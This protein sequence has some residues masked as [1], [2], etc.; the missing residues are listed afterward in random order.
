MAIENISFG[1]G[2]FNRTEKSKKQNKNVQVPE[3]MTT[4]KSNRKHVNLAPYL[5][6]ALMIP[7]GGATLTSCVEQTVSVDE[8]ATQQLLAELLK[9]QQ[10]S[11]KIQQQM[12]EY[13][14]NN[15]S[16]NTQLM[17]LL[18][19]MMEQNQQISNILSGIAGDVSQI[20][21]AVVQ[22]S[23]MME[24][25]NAND[26]ELLN[27][28]DQ[29]IAGQGSDSEKLQQLIDLNAEQNNWLANIFGLIETANQF[30]EKLGETLQ[31]FY[32]DYRTNSDEFKQNDKDHTTMMNL[33]YEALLS[34]NEISTETLNAIKNIQNS[35][36]A[37]SAKLD[38][39]IKLL[40]SI[41]SK[42]DKL[43]EGIDNIGDNITVN[44][45]SLKEILT[46]FLNQYKADKITDHELLNN[47]INAFN[48]SN[49]NDQELLN[50]LN[51]IQAQ[52]ASG[53]LA[54]SEGIDKI[55]DLLNQI[56]S[57][58]DQ[59]VSELQSIAEQLG[60][61]FMVDGKPLA[62]LVKE[63][64]EMYKAGTITTNG[65]LTEINNKIQQGL[66][67]DNANN[68]GILAKLDEISQKISNGQMS[69][70]EGMS[71]ISD[72]LNSIN[73]NIQNISGQLSTISS[74]IDKGIDQLNKNHNETLDMLSNINNGIGSIDSKLND[75]KANQEISNDKL[76][77]ISNK[78]DE[79]NAQLGQINQKTIS[80]DQLKEMLGPMFDE[81]SNDLTII[82]GNQVSIEDLDQLLDKYKTDLTTTN[83]LIENLTS[84]VRNLDLSVDMGEGFQGIIDAINDFKNQQ[85]GTAEQQMA[86]YREIMAAIAD[87]TSSVDA[88]GTTANEISSDLKAHMSQASDYGQ[89]MTDYMLEVINGQKTS[90]D[91]MQEAADS[92][93]EYLNRAEQDRAQQIALLQALV[94]KEVGTNGG[95]LTKEELEEVLSKYQ[96]NV[97]DYSEI[98]NSIYDQLGKVITSDDLQNFYI[99]TR[100]DLTTTNAL[101]ENLTSVLRN[102]DF[103]ISGDVQV[104][105]DQV[106]KIL[107]DIQSLI[108]NQQTPSADQITALIQLVTQ[109]ADSTSQGGDTTR[110]RAVASVEPQRTKKP[111]F[112]MEKLYA[113]LNRLSIEAAKAQGK[114]ATYYVNPEM[115]TL[116]A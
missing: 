93:K 116:N 28:I 36:Q 2:L 109:I 92:Y 32:N 10:E 108:S 11:L 67:N 105:M 71:N 76:T 98:L 14:Q 70:E 30:D 80:I 19:Q 88:L 41:D 23:A 87:L 35:N 100:P 20:A 74:Q 58:L 94:D 95:G 27:K 48:Q 26:E 44:D 55:T 21:G 104:N 112:D 56:K 47:I 77:D 75:I 15:D 5:A 114:P 7:A 102:K 82:G 53:Q 113:N 12:L 51:D 65:L 106:E 83:G 54:V 91:A 66:D 40:E 52:I 63:F 46:E 31:N 68:A 18:K 86:A 111:A 8:S 17:N 81:I 57:S 3:Q 84:V 37:D 24:T 38:A 29:I 9:T 62:Q 79:A 22:I 4:T 13:L 64:M 34:N 6:A 107:G 1:K 101:I 69:I 96:I 39:I 78:I 110:T 72:I 73:G 43:Q 49:I 33:I 89:L 59:I 90:I 60:D 99:N 50:K 97:P 45:E 103:T 115:F 25:A 85:A 16:Q 61:N 42:L